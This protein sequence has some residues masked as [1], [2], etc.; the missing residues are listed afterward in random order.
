LA[1]GDARRWPARHGCPV[2]CLGHIEVIDASDLLDDAVRGAIPDI[3]AE[4]QEQRKQRAK[5]CSWQ[6]SVPNNRPSTE[7]N[8][9]GRS[10]HGAM[11]EASALVICRPPRTPV[12]SG[13]SILFNGRDSDVDIWRD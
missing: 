9:E 3:H 5:R 6:E 7:I 10:V 11:N 1:Q 12:I 4:S 13:P 8:D 2:G